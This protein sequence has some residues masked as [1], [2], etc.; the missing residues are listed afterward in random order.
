MSIEAESI[1]TH[2][3]KSSRQICSSSQVF[4]LNHCLNHLGLFFHF[5]FKIKHSTFFSRQYFS[6]NNIIIACHR[7]CDATH[8][9]T[10]PNPLTLD[11]LA[12]HPRQCTTYTST[13]PTLAHYPRQYATHASKNSTF[14]KISDCISIKIVFLTVFIIMFI[15]IG[16]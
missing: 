5:C 4:L 2:S 1:K 9:N 15:K 3:K 12:C 14:E 8:T 13:P 10:P 6:N 11:M 7:C 16:S